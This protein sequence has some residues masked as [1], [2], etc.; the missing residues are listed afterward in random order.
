MY[1]NSEIKAEIFQ[2]NSPQQKA[3]DTGSPESQIAL[4][5]FRINHLTQ[6]LKKNKKDKSTQRGLLKLVGKRRRML[7]WLK[8]TDINRYRNLLKELGLRG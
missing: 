7:A 6:H 5:S 1:L 8:K 4:W 3:T 2:K